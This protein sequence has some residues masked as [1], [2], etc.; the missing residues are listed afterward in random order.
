M[1]LEPTYARLYEEIYF[2]SSRISN[3]TAAHTFKDVSQPFFKCMF[4]AI[5]WEKLVCIFHTQLSLKSSICNELFA[6]APVKIFL[7]SHS[8]YLKKNILNDIICSKCCEKVVSCQLQS[9]PC[10]RFLYHLREKTSWKKSQWLFISKQ[11]QKTFY[12]KNNFLHHSRTVFNFSCKHLIIIQNFMFIF[13]RLYTYCS[14]YY[15]KSNPHLWKTSVTHLN[16]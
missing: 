1:D 5:R 15:N 2:Y 14:A 4:N 16:N 10:K 12:N 13:S 3:N 9:M 8:N 11:T 6:I 7:C